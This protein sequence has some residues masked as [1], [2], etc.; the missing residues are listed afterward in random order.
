M[1]NSEDPAQTTPLEAVR[2][3]PAFCRNLSLRYYGI[4]NCFTNYKLQV[5]QGRYTMYNHKMLPSPYDFIQCV[6]EIPS[7]VATAV[8]RVRTLKQTIIIQKFKQ[9]NLTMQIV[10]QNI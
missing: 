3:G 5:Q 6:L 10:A 8:S 2:T 4:S 1:A 9:G 7:P